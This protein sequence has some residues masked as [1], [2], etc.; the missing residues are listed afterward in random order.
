MVI[1]HKDLASDWPAS[2]DAQRLLREGWATYRRAQIWE[3]PTDVYE[4][5]EG[6]VIQLEIAG[7]SEQDL[8]ITLSE[9]TLIVCGVRRDP[10]S[11]QVY[12][13]MEI[14]YGEFRTEIHLPWIVDSERVDAVYE[15][16]FLRIFLPRPPRHQVTVI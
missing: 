1:K 4:N 5:E 10:E 2:L 12:H 9:R 6:L 8:Q 14:R 11:K 3:P 16:G 13:Q 7:V 15:D